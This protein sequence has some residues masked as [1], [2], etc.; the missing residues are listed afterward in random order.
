VT[1]I[2]ITVEKV[3]VEFVRVAYDIEKA[4]QAIVASGLPAYF[5]ERLREAR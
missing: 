1:L 5:A 4:A 2:D 3:S